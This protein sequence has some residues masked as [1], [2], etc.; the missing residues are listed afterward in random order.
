MKMIKGVILTTVLASAI[1]FCSKIDNEYTMEA[2]IIS[3]ADLQAVAVDSVGEVW[4]FFADDLNVGDTI[5]IKFDSNHTHKR[6][7]DRII[8]YE[9]VLN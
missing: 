3:V 6:K 4:E 8:D 5:K 1:C 9:K 2:D 7:D